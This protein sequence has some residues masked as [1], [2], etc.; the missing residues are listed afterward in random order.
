MHKSRT[1][2]VKVVVR[3]GRGFLLTTDH[4]VGL[5]CA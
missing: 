5:K 3:S 1:L 2:E 4:R